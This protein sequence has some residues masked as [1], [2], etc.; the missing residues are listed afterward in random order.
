[1]KI[2]IG[3]K[4]GYF[5]NADNCLGYLLSHYNILSALLYVVV[6]KSSVKYM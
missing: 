3:I 4:R 5:V 1:M 6:D 2:S